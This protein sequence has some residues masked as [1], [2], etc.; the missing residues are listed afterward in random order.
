VASA[1][2]AEVEAVQLEGNVAAWRAM[3]PKQH[4]PSSA[5][6]DPALPGK[7]AQGGPTS[8][9]LALT[10]RGAPEEATAAESLDDN[11][12]IELRRSTHEVKL[13]S[14]GY[15]ATLTEADP[16]VKK[17]VCSPHPPPLDFFLLLRREPT[18]AD[19]RRREQRSSA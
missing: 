16:Q 5:S 11:K 3:S 18:Q 19:W 9:S 12:Y 8:Q 14:D 7:A 1:A 6:A 15:M 2:A 10:R 13:L 4:A 17:R